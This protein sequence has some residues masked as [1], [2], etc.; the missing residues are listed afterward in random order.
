MLLFGIAAGLVILDQITKALVRSSIGAGDI[1][2]PFG[3][4]FLWLIHIQNPGLAFGM[5]FLS[6]L[7]LATI[8]GIAAVALGWY[9]YTNPNLS[10][11]Q[12]LP[13]SLILAGA[14]GNMFDRVIY[15]QVTDFIS[16][17]LPDFLMDRFFVF[18]VAD[19][20]VSVGVTFLLIASFF[21]E[22]PPAQPSESEIPALPGADEETTDEHK[23]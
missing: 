1:I 12:S 20:C 6:P 8:S 2:K 23:D 10:I 16:V 15:R 14:V 5:T 3:N 21:P 11:W 4:D 7:I 9:I 18:N 17:D 13:L 22:P 19:S